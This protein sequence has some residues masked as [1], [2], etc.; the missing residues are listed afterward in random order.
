MLRAG[1]RVCR[2]LRWGVVGVAA[3]L[4]FTATSNDADARGRLQ[5]LR[6]AFASYQPSFASIVVDGNSGKVL[7]ATNADS[8]RHPASLTKIMTLY[9]LFERL[10]NGKIKLTTEMPV[11]AHAASQAP[12]KLGLK[13]GETIRVETAIRAIVTKSANDVAVVVAETLG[14]D[15]TNFAKLMTTK[16]RALGMKGTT[17]RNASGLPEDQ[18]YTTASDQALLGRAIRDRFPSYYQYF[19]T[20]TFEFRGKSVRNHNHLLGAVAGV[21]GIKTGYIHD[22]GFNIVTSVRRDHRDIV[23]VV[24]GG[25][26]ANERDARVRNLIEGNIN[27]AAIKRTAPP[28]G[29]AVEAAETAVKE[30]AKPT[31]KESQ[32]NKDK[33]QQV[34]A[35]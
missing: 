34:A 23:A 18:Q 5:R 1:V 14:G 10:E 22:S 15:E 33:E 12:S 19:S 20:R 6:A 32:D 28:V 9:L 17:Y 7:Q 13:P 30:V 26:T 25:R 2:G 3:L 4:A 11:S 29:E 35:A 16:A 24:F 31:I 8:P 27:T 21:D